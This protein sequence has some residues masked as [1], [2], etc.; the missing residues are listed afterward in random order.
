MDASDLAKKKKEMTMYY[1]IKAQLSTAQIGCIPSVCNTST[2]TYKFPSYETRQDY[3]MGRY[4]VGTSCSTCNTCAK[5][6][7]K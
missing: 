6:S 3:F 4:D 1:N 2:C 5:F 7:Y